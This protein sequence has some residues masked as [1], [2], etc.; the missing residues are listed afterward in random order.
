MQIIF[1]NE[2]YKITFEKG[3]NDRLVIAFSGIALRLG[4]IEKEEFRKTLNTENK[5][6]NICYVI[7]KKRTWYNF[8]EEDISIKLN[9]LIKDLNITDVYTLGNSMGGYGAIIFAKKL[10]NCRKVISFC[11]QYSI[12]PRIIPFERRW[13]KYRQNITQYSTNDVSTEISR[14][15]EYNI[16]FGNQEKLDKKHAKLFLN[17]NLPNMIINIVKGASHNVASYLKMENKLVE[18]ISNIIE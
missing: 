12:N 13:K 18:T 6:N 1:E 17:L 8:L 16:F 4:G 11:P 15:I 2:R 7:D 14:D 3:T 10:D 5:D 9:Y